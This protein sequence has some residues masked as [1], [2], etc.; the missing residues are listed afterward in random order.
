MT[1]HSLGSSPITLDRIILITVWNLLYIFWVWNTRTFIMATTSASSLLPRTD[2]NPTST[3]ILIARL[4]LR[5]LQLRGGARVPEELALQI[6]GHAAYR[7]RAVRRRAAPR[8]YAANDFWEPGPAA[9]VAGLYLTTDP[10]PRRRCRAAARVTLQVRS[11]DQGWADNGGDG[12]YHNSHTWFDACVLRPVGDDVD[13]D[14]AAA[15]VAAAAEMG[16]E[17]RLESVLTTTFRSPEDARQDLRERGWD[18]VERDGRST[19]MVHHNSTPS[20]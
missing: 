7:R 19:W 8:E 2:F 15:A 20:E 17:G 12:T 4:I 18:I 9:R 1:S 16:E 13:E 11:A 3:D 5:G 10:L 14:D 6:L